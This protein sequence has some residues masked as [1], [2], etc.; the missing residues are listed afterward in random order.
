MIIFYRKIKAKIF[1]NR[2]GVSLIEVSL[3]LSIAATISI[4]VLGL[5]SSA[6]RMQLKAQKL[7]L[8]SNLARAKMTQILSMPVLEPTNQKGA[9]D[10]PLYNGFEY[11]LIIREE[12]ID[13][14][15]VSQ[16]G[17]LDTQINVDDQLPASVQN[18]KGKEKAVEDVTATGALIPI[19]RIIV[20]ITFPVDNKNKNTYEVVSIKAAKQL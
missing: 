19:Y 10:I 13:L 2:K 14:A 11:E 18:Y 12:N 16:T 9:L 20:K 8:A 5:V 15:K 1:K 17:S 6:Y 3:A 7:E 4:S